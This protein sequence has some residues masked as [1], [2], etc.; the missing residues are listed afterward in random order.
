MANVYSAVGRNKFSPLIVRPNEPLQW[1]DPAGDTSGTGRMLQYDAKKVSV[2]RD[3][4]DANGNSNPDFK[5]TQKQRVIDGGSAFSTITRGYIRRTDDSDSGAGK[6]TLNFMFNP[7]QITRDYVSYMDQ[8]ALDPFNTLYQSG[9]L[10]APPSFVNFTFSLFFDRQDDMFSQS[11]SSYEAAKSGVLIDYKYFDIVVRNV[12]P[13]GR[14]TSDVPDNGVMMVNPRDI[15][16]VFSKDLTVQGRPTNARV[17]FTKFNHEMVPTRMQVDLTMIITY[18]GPYLKTPYGMNTFKAE[19]Q[20]EAMVPYSDSVEEGYSSEDLKA[21]ISEYKS[22][23]ASRAAEPDTPGDSFFDKYLSAQST[24]SAANALGQVGG[25]VG[26]SAETNRGIRLAALQRAKQRVSTTPPPTYASAGGQRTGPNS[27][28]PSGLLWAAYNDVGAAAVLDGQSSTPCTVDSIV[29]HQFSNNWKTMPIVATLGQDK[30]LVRA[31]LQQA[32]EPG[33]V[34]IQSRGRAGKAAIF[35]GWQDP[36]AK[37]MATVISAHGPLIGVSQHIEGITLVCSEYDWLTRPSLGGSQS[38]AGGVLGS[39]VVG[40]SGSY[41]GVTLAE[42][43]ATSGPRPYASALLQV[44]K[45]RYSGTPGRAPGIDG[46]YNRRYIGNNAKNGW[47]THAAGRGIDYGT[48]TDA[49]GYAFGQALVT[50]L[51]SKAS[52]L[53]IQ[54]IIFTNGTKDVSYKPGKAPRTISTNVHRN[55]LHIEIN[56]AV[57]DI[58]TAS[59]IPWIE[60]VLG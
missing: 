15:T 16:V 13:D 27:Y 8:A 29:V 1:G 18:F 25:T 49:T 57:A 7:E 58:P 33:D 35:V 44:L 23:Q 5:F 48:T 38:V 34:L 24:S 36:E 42:V 53:G 56:R 30:P 59:A 54:A 46:I 32:A 51:L 60:G 14:S 9:N 45:A 43:N 47:S 40:T 17:Q 12:A 52:Q 3:F 20:Y 55:H 26:V 28:D 50:F 2:I 4:L 19:K 39:S 21:A 6:A 11:G 37:T 10:V 22:L 31:G 41:D